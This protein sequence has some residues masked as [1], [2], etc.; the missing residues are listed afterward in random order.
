MGAIVGMDGEVVTRKGDMKKRW[1]EYFAHTVP[2]HKK[3]KMEKEV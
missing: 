1:N 3:Q 2:F